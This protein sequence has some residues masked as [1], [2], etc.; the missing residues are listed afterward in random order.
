[1]SRSRIEDILP[2]SPL[3]EGLLFH[4][5]YDKQTT[6]VYTAQLVFDIEGAVDVEALRAAARTL[7]R[8]HANLR[9]GFSQRKSG[10]SVQ[11]IHREVPLPWQEFDLSGLDEAIRN[12]E[13]TR[14]LAEDRFR[15]FDVARPPL[16]RFTLIRCAADRWRFAL[17]NHHILW[18][19]WSTPVLV[20][21]LFQLYAQ[22][23]D[24]TGM[25]RVTP[26]R[27]YLAWLSRQ[28]RSAAERAWREALAG[29]TEP[30]FLAS[31]GARREPV[32]PEDVT[33]VVPEELTHRLGEVARRHE[34]TL[35][36]VVQGMWAILLGRLTGRDDVVFGATVSG[37]PPELPGVETMVGL[38]I[39]TLPV[40]V[41]LRPG[42]SLAELLTG[43]Q[44]QQSGLTDHQ[45]VGLGD[46]QRWIGVGELFDTLTV[47]EN[48]PIDPAFLGASDG[49]AASG[50]VRVLGMSG[51]DAIHYPL[52]L[53]AALGS[54]LE[55]RLSYRPDLFDEETARA[56][57]ARLVRLLEAL[58]A[59]PDQLVGETTVLSAGERDRLLT[60]WND[61]ACSLPEA[62]LVSLLE[63]VAAR[64]PER[65]A[66]ACE[67]V[68]LSY[69]KLNERANRLA[70]LL[71]ERGAGPERFVGV[72]VPRSVEMVVALLAVLK[73]GAAY[74]PIDPSYPADR[75]G[76]M[77]ADADP[78][79][80]IVTT[81]TAAGL[82]ETR[83]PRI[84]LD[85]PG[86]LDRYPDGNPVDAGRL[87]PVRP[88]HPAYMIYTS[89]STGRPKGVVVSR[90]NLLNL[91]TVMREVL[92]LTRD[93]R[94]L[95]VTTVAFDI[96][97]VDVY[98]PLLAGA[99][100]VIAVEDTVRDPAA[101]A[102][103]LVDSGATVLQATPSLW[104]ELVP[105]LEGARGLRALLGGEALSAAL[106]GRLR[107]LG[108]EVVNGYG[109]TEATVYSVTAAVGELGGGG[110]PIGRPVG[111]TRLYVLDPA[112]RLVPVGTV[113]ELY[114]AGA[115]VARGYHGRPGLSA[116][117]FVADPFGGPGE[118]MYRT[119]DLVRWKASGELEYLGRVD[120]QV[121]VR[122]FRIELGEIEAVLAGH[123]GV[124]QVAVVVREDRPG[125]R[126]LVAYVVPGGPV[127]D[128][129]VLRAHVAAS[130]PDYMVPAVFVAMD[131][132]PLTPNRKLDR[133]ALP[134]P[135]FTVSEAGRA[136]RSPQEELLCGV[137][138]EVLGVASVG[139]EDD[140]F[141]LGGHSL[142]AT[143]L[144]SRVRS[145]LGVELA[146]R[147]VFEA[148]SVAGLAGR[149][150]TAAGARLAVR[151]MARPERVPL[152]FA[153][154]RLWFL[155]KL[156]GPS[157]TYNIPMAVR[158]SGPLDRD[159]LRAALGDVVERHES[160]R[161]VFP[162]VDGT[163]RQVIL[164][165][166][167]AR[168]ELPIVDVAES[169]LRERIAEVSG[170]GFDLE[171]ELPARAWLF[172]LGVDEHVLVVV[173]HH[174]ATD[175]AS[176][177]PLARDLSIAYAARC[178]GAAPQWSPLPVQYADY[179]LWQH[180]VLGSESDADSV[181]SA[182]V[183]HWR[184]N[185]AG[186]PE[187]LTLPTDHPRPA[188]PSYRG[189]TVPFAVDAELHAGLVELARASGSTVFMVVQ[190]ALAA[191][192][193]RLGAGTDIPIGTPI[194]GR[195]DDALDELVGFF[196]NT[197]VLRTDTSGDPSF[198]ELLGRVRE[199]DLAAYANQ[200]LPFERLV[201]VLNPAR[202]L[203]RHP[204]FQ[205]MLSFQNV[206]PDDPGL[207]GVSVTPETAGTAA[208]KFDLSFNIGERFDSHGSP[209]GI[210]GAIEYSLDLF[211]R[212]SVEAIAEWL[213]RLLGE[214]MAEPDRPVVR[215]YVLDEG[216]R[217]VPDG[218]TGALYVSGAGLR[219]E[220][221][222]AD[223]FGEPG[224]L[225]YATGDVVRRTASGV[226]EFVERVQD[227]TRSAEPD[228]AVGVR[229]PRS[230]REEILCELFAEVLGVS[231]VGID[232][233]FFD[234]GGHSLLATRLVSRIRAVLGVE[235]AVRDL[236]EAPTV[237]GLAGLLGTAAGARPPVRR[238]ARPERIPLSFAQ[239]RL[240]FIHQ[241]E[242][243]SATYNTPM[244]L[245]L[246]GPLDRDAL[247]AALG[248]VVERHESLRTVFPDVDGTPYQRVLPVEEARPRLSVVN[249]AESELRE[250]IAE[251][252]GHG[253]DLGSELPV[254]AWLFALGAEEHV[255]AVVVHHIATDGA[256]QTPLARDLSIAYAARCAGAA[257]QWSPLPVQYADYTLWQREVLGDEDDADSLISQQVDHWRRALAGLPE[258]LVLP[259]DRPRP[260]EI[261][262]RGGTLTFQLDRELHAGLV[263]L[264][265]ASGSTVFMVVQAGL[266][267]LLT[268]LGAGTDIPIGTPIA[269][270]TDDALDELV[271]FFVNSLVLRTDTSGDPSFRELL[272]RVRETGLAAYANQD[273]PFERLV[274]IL[275][276]ER[277]LARHPLFQVMLT[278][279]NHTEV[280]L[281]LPG[282]DA[283][284]EQMGLGIAK[285]DLSF[286]LGERRTADGELDGIEGGIEYS[287]DLFDPASVRAIADRFIRLLTAVVA[288]PDQP[289]SHIDVLSADERR[290]VLVEWNDTA[291]E[292]DAVCLP[293]LFER[294][295]AAAPDNAAVMFEGGTLSYAELNARANRLAHHLIARGIG[296]ERIVA[297][298]MPRSVDLIVAALAVGKAGGAY[299]PI[300][301]NYPDER[302]AFM[303]ADAD[304]ALVLTTIEASDGLPGQRGGTDSWV[305]IDD[306]G[307]VSELEGRS[308]RNPTDL[309]RLAPLRPAHP[310]YVIYTSGSTGR[311]KGVVVS[312][313]GIA[314]FAA[315]LVD[316]FAVRPDSRVLQFSSPSFD[317]AVLELCAAFGA[318]ACLVVPEEGPLAGEALAEVLADRAITHALIPPAALASVPSIDLPE[319]RTL[320]VGGDAC[321]AE[322]VAKWAPGRRMINAYGPTESTVAATLS[323]PLTAGVPP[324]G[325]PLWNSRVYVL[326]EH[327]RLVPPGQSG[328]LYIAGAGLARG[329][330]GRSGLT[331]E[332]FVA[333][334]FGGPGER[335]YRTGDVVRWNASGELEF[336]GRAD[337]QVKV[338]GFRIE[339]GE[340]EA[341]LA[342]HAAVA[343]VA[344]VVREDRPGGRRLVAYVVPDSGAVDAA[345]LRTHLSRALPDYMVPAAFVAL[346]ALPLTP[347]GK[348]D[349]KALPAPGF[350]TSTSGRAPRTPREELLCGLFA[351]VLG[352][353][354]VGAGDSFF[355]LGG[356]S[357]MS[358]QLVSRARKAGLVF[359]PKDVFRCKTVEALAAVA[360][361]TG[362]PSPEIVADGV[363]ELP[364]TPIIHWLRERGGPIDRFNQSTLLQVPAGLTIERLTEVV[365]AVLDH[366]D[367]LRMRL[368]RVPDTGEWR[369]DIQEKGAVDAG[370][371]VRRVDVAGLTEEALRATVSEQV[372]AAQESLSPESGDVV[373]IVWF[374]AG[375]DRSGWLMLVLHHLVVD[376]VSWR[377]LLPDLMVAYQAVAAGRSPELEPV[378]MSFRGWSLLLAEQAT[379]PERVAELSLWTEMLD[380]S[381]PLLGARPVDPARDVMGTAGHVRLSLS[382]ERTTP[383][384]TVV[385]S[386]F[387]AGVND[388][389]LTA[390]SLA[391]GQWRSRRGSAE[392]AVLVSLEAHGREEIVDGIDLSRTVGWFTSLFPVRLDPDEL[393][394]AEVAAGGAATGTALKRV[395]EQLRA[396]PDNGIGYG[397]LR[398]QNPETS[399]ALAK[400]PSP[401]IMFNYLGRMAATDESTAEDWAPAPEVGGLGG[402]TDADMPLAHALEINA[403]TEDHADG[404][405]LA[406]NLTF[407]PGV[408]SEHDVRELA[409]LWFT[410]LGALATHTLEQG[411]GGLTPS[412]LPLVR[413][414]QHDIDRLEAEHPR[415]LD[416][417]PL[418]PLQ[419]GLLFH[420]GYDEQATDVYTVQ[421]VFELEGAVKVEVMQ[422]AVGALLRRHANLRA[423]FWAEELDRPVQFIPA[424][425]T[426]PWQEFDL[427]EL[428]EEQAEA[429]VA[430][431]IAEDRFRRFDM[432]R[433]PLMRFTLI[434]CAGERYRFVV[435]SHHILLD[436]WSTP[437]MVAELFRL[438][439]TGCDETDLPRVTPYRD[440]L[441]W[442]DR[443]DRAAAE[444]AWREALSGLTEPTLL[445]SAGRAHEPVIPGQYVVELSEESTSTLHSLA[446]RHE[447]TL[448]T[449]IQGAWAILLGGLTGRDDVVFG[450]TVSGR[451]AEVPGIETMV[452]L[453]INTLPTRARL[454][455]GM[456]GLELLTEIQDR[457][458]RLTDHQHLG[459]TDIQRLAGVGE[460][461]DTLLVFENYPVD[462]DRL[463]SSDAHDDEED[464]RIT[465]MSADDSVHYPL[466]LSVFP[467]S[468]FHLRFIYRPDLFGHD[469]VAELGA[470]LVRL[471][472]AMAAEPDRPI[473]RLDLLSS[474][475]HERLLVAWNDTARPLPSSTLPELLQEQAERDPER[476]A[477]VF[478]ETQLSYADLNAR[479][480]RLAHHLIGQG[481]G[482]EQ[483]VAVAVPRSAEMVVA[484]L[485]VLK[486]GAAYLPIDPDYPAERIAY[487]LADAEPVLVLTTSALASDVPAGQHVFVLDEPG[488]LAV[489]D[490]YTGTD[491]A[492][493][494][495]VAV[496][497]PQSPAYV[498]YTSGSTGRPKGVVVPIASLLNLLLDMAERLSV[499]PGDRFLAVTTFGFDI[500]NLELFVPL[501]SGAR[502]VIAS[503]DVVRDPAALA[504][505]ITESGATLM[506]ATPSLWHGMVTEHAHSLTGL[507]VLVGGEAVSESLAAALCSVAGG[508]VN[509]Y[510][511]TETTIWST[512]AVLD[513]AAGGVPPI[514]RPLANTRVYVL[515]SAVRPV[516]VGTAGEL[517]VAGDGVARGYLGRP[518][519]TAERFVADPFDGSGGRMYRTGDVV[520][521]NASGELEYLGRADDQVKIRG[522]RVELGEIEAVLA[523]HEA[524]SHVAVV[525]REDGP[526]DKRLVAYAVPDSGAV[527]A[528]D[529]RTHLSRALPDYMVPAAFVALD[530]LPLTPNGKLDRKALPAPELDSEIGRGPRTPREEIL[531]GLFAE[532]L[533]LPMV[534]AEDDFFDLGGHSLLATRLVSR[535]RASLD[536][537]LPIRAVFETP[538]VAGLAELLDGGRDARRA[539]APMARPGLIP[540]SF[541]QR[542]LWFLDRLE[543]DSATYNIPLALRL[544]GSLDRQALHAALHDVVARHESLRTVFPETGGEPRQVILDPAE[545]TMEL[546]ATEIDES[547]LAAALESV[548][549]KGFDLAAE[550]PVRAELFVL[551]PQEHVLV[552]VLHHIAS[553]GWSQAPL[554]RDLS[555]AYTARCLGRAPDWTPLP[556]QYADYALWQQEVLGSEHDAD[557]VIARQAHFWT[558]TLAGAP[559][560]LQLPTDRMRPAVAS[561]RGDRI[562]YRL[563]AQLHHGLAALARQS[564]TSLFMV[565]QAALAALLTRLGAG[566]DIPVGT[567][568]AGRTDDA[569]DELVGFFVNT[570]VLRTDTSGDPSFRELLGRVRETDL[571]AYANQDVPFERLV[572]ILNPARSLAHHPLF[573]VMLSFHNNNAGG[574]APMPGL[575]V[576]AEH[577]GTAVAKFDLSF[578]LGELPAEHGALGGL[579]GS[580]EFATDLFDR[581]TVETIAER[582]TRL[583]HAMVDAPERTLS[584]VDIL[585]PGE[586]HRLLVEWN[587]TVR[588]LPEADV[589]A[590]FEAQAA[591]S[592]SHIAVSCEGADLS[593]AELNARANQLAHLLIEEG[594]GPE[595]FVAL[596]L[597]RSV[598]LVVALLAVLKT[599]AAYL[600][601]DPGYPADR[602]GY[603]LADADPACVIATAETAAALPGTQSGTILLDQAADVGRYPVTDPVDADRLGPVR[604]AHP[605]YMI[606]TSGSTGRPKGVVV[607]RKNLVNFLT[608]IQSVVPLDPHDRLLAVTTIAFDIAAVDVYL[609]LLAGAGV[610]IAVEDT[611]RDPAALAG[612]LVDSGATVLQATPSLW[613]ELVPELEGARGLRAL[614]GGEALPAALAGRLRELGCEVVNGYGPTEAT[615]YS[616]TAAVGELDGGGAP[617]G[618]PVGNTRLYVLDPALR[619]VPVGTVGELYIA[620]AGVAR[621]YH[622][623]PG[624]S[625]ERFVADPFGGPGERMYRTGDL[626]R[627]SA[628]GDMEYLGR[629]DDQVKVRG[630]RIELGEIEAV[631]AGHAG[632]AQV[633]VVVREDRP[634]DRRLVAYVVPGG[635]VVDAA[636]LRAHVAA[637]LPDYMVPAVFVAMDGLPLTPNRKLD[638]QA[639]PA[640]AFTVSEG[641]RAPRGPQEELLCGVFAE[642]LGVAS[643]GVDDDFFVLGGHSLLATRLVS[644]VRSVLG[645]ELAVRAVFEAPSVAGLAGRLGTAA[646]ARLAVRPMVRPERVPLSF[647]QRR[648]WFLNKLEGPSATYNIPMAVRLSGP[649]DRDALRDAI[650]DVLARH[651]SLRTVFPDV[652]GV[653][654]QLV[655]PE[656]HAADLLS[657]VDSSEDTVVDAVAE[658]SRR[659][660]ALADGLPMRATLFVLGPEE[661]VLCV[662]VHHIAGDG[663]S[664]T[665]LSRDLAAAYA[666][667]VRG[668]SPQWSSLPVQYADYT[669][670]QLDLLGDEADPDSAL[671]RQVTHWR[672]QLEGLP[673]ELALPFDR[674]R[675]S[676]SSYGGDSVP[677][678][679]DAQVHGR[680]AELARECNVS[681]FMVVQAALAALLT[682]LGAGTDIPVGTPIAGRTDEAL[683]ELV[684]FF[685]NT[686]VL[687]TDTS[688]DPSFRELLGRVRETDLAAYAN[689]DV[690]FERLVEMV[691]PVRSLGR[692]PLFQT[693]LSFQNAAE[694]DFELPELR[695]APVMTAAGAAKFD[696]SFN[697]GERHTADAGQDGIG[698]NVEYSTDLFDRD[699]VRAIAESFVR[700]LAEVAA[701]PDRPISRFDL[702]SPAERQRVLSEWTAPELP[703]PP[704][705]GAQ[706]QPDGQVR[707]YVL[708]AALR[709]SPPGLPGRLYVGG[710][711]LGARLDTAI[712]TAERLVA[713][714]FGGPGTRMYRTGELARWD[715]SGTLRLLSDGKPDHGEFGEEAGPRASGGRY[716]AMLCEIFAEVLGLDE[717]E[718]DENFFDLGGHSLLAMRLISRVRSALGVE[719]NIQT[720]FEA[721]TVAA[722]ASRLAEH[723]AGDFWGSPLSLRG[724]GERAPLFCVHPGAGL[725]L[726]YSVLIR[727][728][729]AEHP[730]YGLQAR[731]LSKPHELPA[732]VEE[733]AEDYVEQIRTIQPHGPYHLLGWSFGGAVVHAMAVRLQEEGEQVGTLALL[734]AYPVEQPVEPAELDGAEIDEQ[735]VLR[736]ILDFVGYDVAS[737]GDRRLGYEQVQEMLRQTDTGLP[738]LEEHHLR[739][740]AQ[741]QSNNGDLLA[742]YVPRMFH[743]DVLFF[744]ALGDDIGT[745]RDWEPYVSG[746]LHNHEI[747]CA[748]KDMM[749]PEPAEAIGRVVAEW[750]GSRMGSTS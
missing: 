302:V 351:E 514:G 102:G 7:L 342:G 680:L 450:A 509:V 715:D 614:L 128:A 638:R 664:L 454:R 45:H 163:P 100:V 210:S 479:A 473:G 417:L 640:P 369:L 619:L 483:V 734:D 592:P 362:E 657:I 677:F 380:V 611:V 555:T 633:A 19:G 179:T 725:S 552:L 235:L 101:L 478:E 312:H 141:V 243:P 91:V 132:L 276:P 52:G 171:S 323:E 455:P 508:V 405:R 70:R 287:A 140:F 191:L 623:R 135:A 480:N 594:A 46:I 463:T 167:L 562:E 15:R 617:I 467:G 658:E 566:T 485:A 429:E 57:A 34:L 519:L 581:A 299:L 328:E 377:V 223:P 537:E 498:L 310:A 14:L 468:R 415:L 106:A 702:S 451:P 609:P 204:L 518:G 604:E 203:S 643:V 661:Y 110:A 605:A 87:G 667:R 475:E 608:A 656:S 385:P 143:R 553:D 391:V 727:H 28:D 205:V 364:L 453:F 44:E 265:R 134:A 578:E 27:D 272:G 438:Y 6:D 457:Q 622:G 224:S 61:T 403:V 356:D 313:Q 700:L 41:R 694:I 156:E 593:Y 496:P 357:I 361:S 571:A 326:D 350:A 449:V 534:G 444:Q 654:Y 306:A 739:A 35:N 183:D 585:E 122:G 710:P 378:S 335:M 244:A 513:G 267:A 187:E 281:E 713:D 384:L 349:R 152:S 511:P 695:V 471:L 748:H 490:G 616:V 682:R 250:R 96:A 148:P 546:T 512:S 307:T 642:V 355:E 308:T 37:R 73:T 178:A 21:E 77:L 400:L 273:V 500:A 650:V 624:L 43:L 207:A 177:T 104:Q 1:M 470:R 433:P 23:G 668:A 684:G 411:S 18:D 659:P 462:T 118:R 746:Q 488:S 586:R 20:S 375:P 320:V 329:Y 5:L 162:E 689:Q 701:D 516:P 526:G 58:V 580:V 120:D 670:W 159:A 505:L 615:V 541:A 186:L 324:I 507:R 188:R 245:R 65:V 340:V 660:F 477:V 348:L 206:A 733:M 259:T 238:A 81:V 257:P 94:L 489:L 339:L 275:N 239:R 103:L 603:M 517:Y 173:I 75:I 71:V 412:D 567:P 601:I 606:Y 406:V 26:Y 300:D 493:A 503:R 127:V 174:I 219:A 545:I 260:A 33:V 418:S 651:E 292:V 13:L 459:L 409:E 190:A 109:P 341:V 154:R 284:S 353:P 68:E 282:L 510:G 386:A 561:Y 116:E 55:L 630:F 54:S 484:A 42:L 344:V 410:A 714:P 230:P 583:L 53:A 288:A 51:Q 696:L 289:I 294:Q 181:I 296:P 359:T 82:P 736:T 234:L 80:V 155:N 554:G 618:R 208:A 427:T 559:E 666:A 264:A 382:A 189:D 330:L 231:E 389:L 374:D 4:A 572:E 144:V 735:D 76:Y 612:L 543:D 332:R 371:C 626:V 494:D 419:E 393:D 387:H 497:G 242:G 153:Q 458:S 544:S 476:I 487:M 166:A 222:V 678:T 182:Q 286:N 161:T 540:L 176:Q 184:R 436:G 740:L 366:H 720:L 200:D 693:V 527:D 211:D 346:D 649:L 597:P 119:G 596:V 229:G 745:V 271:G 443:Q 647:A 424:E 209:D 232:E 86:V 64:T 157:A 262:Y 499:E 662:V 202:S 252:S 72:V 565:V 214:V 158:L 547:E 9:A 368:T 256:S 744:T 607:S 536:V 88:E 146:V 298:A 145:V 448:N 641:G 704:S 2:L 672:R 220:R 697:L 712:L 698:G 311:P 430:R 295:V 426:L 469:D 681:V 304:P 691:N 227:R 538:T 352:L 147:A 627:W 742:K 502:L 358:I 280:T 560:Q 588:A 233:E 269:G 253:F 216:L 421:L 582:F 576:R 293:E 195:T 367:A 404:P 440:Y 66:V 236:F 675:P 266:A 98:L 723:S 663:W 316:R 169:G 62:D 108:C 407:P 97:A 635:S 466:G 718:A 228:G 645:V 423:G 114:I 432:A 556:V 336:V 240:W 728:I 474:A 10:E 716:E 628:E 549:G 297:L 399:Q 636:V 85:Q 401:Q 558:E 164:D 315:A 688:G 665:P 598:E 655:L 30:T 671:A 185:L 579:W 40:R 89:G 416:V 722:L 550:L 573:Q 372:D 246:R 69:A 686:L 112:L 639:L 396:V 731:G 575:E 653:P 737:L 92:P 464:V 225:M 193:T 381:E 456:S 79:C 138:A 413:L 564:Q 129:A 278:F 441:E 482:P 522:H 676:M 11:I 644:R 699:T 29:V 199:T 237:A 50:D 343:Q 703:L 197:L 515:D 74:V 523:A 652:G 212:G 402:A 117:R 620:G 373:R 685:V 226:L 610:V 726:V 314:S 142:L 634:G 347:N 172:A 539:L 520:R 535:I 67:D 160:L 673:E 370:R 591:R 125:D 420:A 39:N 279:Q 247:Q 711:G 447:L 249:V 56:I 60:E 708:D 719:L 63:A 397:L 192:L 333:D 149:L 437:L 83:T 3:Q 637:S 525:V 168:P 690:P 431:L 506:Q 126:R 133:Q 318:G 217:P 390:L 305:V 150:G 48:Y 301:P 600:P 472:E 750:L 743:G 529:L 428:S 388:V 599:G 8:R 291:R 124:A 334:P 175:G 491:P 613:Q 595:R 137:F 648:L 337:D 215:T 398:Y 331:A 255:L 363:G 321:T 501:L 99:G 196:V 705:L 36:T 258:E 747:A 486:A 394:W 724:T 729:G 646:G 730:I 625:A 584:E 741:V 629:V 111:N 465:G 201:E 531:C 131:G 123:A 105:Q 198:R 345:E 354:A 121:K 180:E 528:A 25:P 445:T 24:D 569:L 414:G 425:V 285:F 49:S 749:Q 218:V 533:G 439:A 165:A 95:A 632:V 379:K 706:A 78:A 251:V 422:A 542:R 309:D 587:D 442:L 532:V 268:R 721:P 303:L 263:E 151:P 136:P 38:L 31:P 59:N 621:G 434:R 717:V 327:L 319:F 383:L 568:I 492:D 687:R 738:D 338:R 12:G 270:R 570:L 707:P 317:A 692:H 435:S 530:A 631:L 674:P 683:D 408:L 392:S 376:G 548:A 709:L 481:I 495:R 557:S 524:V 461:F 577:I 113:G 452:G 107:E 17:T 460:L 365:R 170:H 521:W 139:V 254:R 22:G 194:A 290:R 261:S 602:I 283:G 130:L 732:T 360:R 90:R 277:S 248:D 563:D 574:D 504:E 221:F 241:M 115:G 551:A 16:V 679:L 669:L 446:R 47:F 325:R 395:K 274:E 93:D 213:V 590:L 322:L 84:L 32:V 589:P